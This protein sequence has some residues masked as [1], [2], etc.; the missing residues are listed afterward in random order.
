MSSSER[1]GNQRG[2]QLDRHA[3]GDGGSFDAGGGEFTG[4]RV[5]FDDRAIWVFDAIEIVVVIVGQRLWVV[6]LS[7]PMM[8]ALRRSPLTEQDDLLADTQ[9]VTA[10]G[11][12]STQH[13]IGPPVGVVALGF[14]AAFTGSH[15]GHGADADQVVD[16]AE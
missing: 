11:A 4:G 13:Q 16:F 14:D 15:F 1:L 3:G 7:E 12:T 6:A 5:V 10:A 9:A 2:D 8:Y